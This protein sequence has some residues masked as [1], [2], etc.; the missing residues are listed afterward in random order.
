MSWIIRSISI[1]E[2]GDFISL[3]VHP[4]SGLVQSATYGTLFNFRRTHGLPLVDLV[5]K[6]ASIPAQPQPVPIGPSSYLSWFKFNQT[7]SG[8]QIDELCTCYYTFELVSSL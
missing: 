6:K 2:S 5:S 3:R 1:D 8:Q 7:L 4:S